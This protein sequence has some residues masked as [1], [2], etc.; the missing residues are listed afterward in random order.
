MKKQADQNKK[1]EKIDA[2][3]PKVLFRNPSL[4]EQFLKQPTIKIA[5]FIT[6]LLAV[7]R[8]EMILTGG[9][10]VQGAIKGRLMIQLGR[11][12]KNL[13]GRGQIKE[14]Y[15]ETKFGF[16]SL[17]EILSFIDSE[18]PDEDRFNAAK[19]M[20]FALNS[21]D[22]KTS[23]EEM[24][25]YH[26]F[27]ITLGLTSTQIIILKISYDWVR[28]N[29]TPISSASEWVRKM[30]ESLGHGIGDLVRIDES[31]LVN[32]HLISKRIHPDDSDSGVYSKNARLTDLGMSFCGNLSKYS[33]EG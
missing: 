11:E 33:D 24:L 8:E 13:L 31:V 14:D 26:L 29:E 28:N 3:K 12:I 21:I 15:A 6:G 4:L 2:L 32:N 19:A 17:E 9:R 1:V 30:S 18:A 7:G 10:L 25:R 23:G 5:E 27:K 16:K 22:V 20:F